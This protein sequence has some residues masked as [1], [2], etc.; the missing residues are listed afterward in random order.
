MY[1][2]LRLESLA[3][4]TALGFDGYAL[5]G[6]SVGE[7]TEEMHRVLDVVTPGMPDDKPR[8]LMGVGR[9]EDIVEA[10]VRGIDMFD[11]V[12]PTRNARNGWLFTNSGVVKIRN[13]QY[14][15]DTRPIDPECSCYTCRYYTRSYLRHLQRCNE[16]LGA[17]L[18]TLHNL[19]Y[20]QTL[21]RE[22]RNAVEN[23]SLA[24]FVEDFYR[25]RGIQRR[26]MA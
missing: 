13:A 3:G 5:G 2:D 17:H 23:Q 22:L 8:Y 11:C 9:P 25:K 20:Y 15:E 6:L 19:H 10:V 1:D 7:P 24:Q 18:A 4:L 12:M 26:D 21:M 16:I 14:A